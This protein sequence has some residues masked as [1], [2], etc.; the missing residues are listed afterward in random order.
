MTVYLKKNTRTTIVALPGDGEQEQEAN[1]KD[2]VTEVELAKVPSS[3]IRLKRAQ[4]EA[5]KKIAQAAITSF[6][7]AGHTKAATQKNTNTKSVSAMLRR[8][9]EEVVAERHKSKTSQPTIEQCTKKDKEAKQ[10]ID[11]HVADFFYENG[12]P[13][14]VIN[15]RSWEI[16]LESIGHPAGTFFLG[17]VDASSEIAN[18]Q[19]LADLLEQQV[20]KIGKEYMVQVVTNNGANFKAAKRILIERIPHLFWTPCAAHCLNLLLQDIGEIKEFNTAI[21]WGKKVCRFLYKHGRIL[22]LMRQKICGD[23]VR[24]VVTRF[25]TSYLTLASMYKHK[26]GLRALVVSKEWQVNSMSNNS[27][28]K[29][30]EDIVLSMPFWNRVECCLRASQPFLVALRIADGD[31]TPTAP[32]IMAAMDHTKTTIKDSLK[33]KTDLLKEVM[34]RYDNRWE[35]QNAVEVIWS[36]PILEFSEQSKI[37]R[38]ADDYEQSE[39]EGFSMPLVIRDRDKKNPIRWWNS[40]GGYSFELQSLAK[41]IISLCCSAS[42]CELPH[43][44]RNR[45]EHKRLN[46]LI[47]VSYNKK[48][49]NRFQKIRELGCKG[50]KNNPLMLDEFQWDNEWVD[51]NCEEST[52]ATIDE[53]IGASENLQGR[54]LPRAAATRA[55]ASVSQMY[56][57]KRPSTAAAATTAPDSIDDEDDDHEAQVQPDTSNAEVGMEVDGD[58]GGDG[59][60]GFNLDD[61]LLI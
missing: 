11:D 3:R 18:A 26:N 60:G 24:P 6:V 49:S 22:D 59:G 28:G 39:G 16:M 15:S 45:L 34:K 56:I 61:D 37:S 12:I 42:G 55:A 36:S 58:S 51:A 8:T 44:K 1:E 50:Q 52:W 38:Q 57:S 21:N 43:K 25:A 29:Q 27:E 53:A 41:K 10:I 4:S 2:E 54:N 17:S 14:N 19:M 48:M 47:Y 32:E 5:K 46:K 40:Y 30:V 35:N 20:D 31:E 13:F 33:A 9:P 7:V 23:L